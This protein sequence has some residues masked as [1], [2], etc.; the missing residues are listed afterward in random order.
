M[1]KD[2]VVRTGGHG[3]SRLAACGGS[4]GYQR[5]TTHFGGACG[6]M[7]GDGGFPVGNGGSAGPVLSERVVVWPVSHH[8]ASGWMEYGNRLMPETVRA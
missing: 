5:L 7:T 8:L 6:G 2:C 3:L 4:V 1:G